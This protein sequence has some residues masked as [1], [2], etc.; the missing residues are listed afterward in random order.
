MFICMTLMTAKTVFSLSP[1]EVLIVYNADKSDSYAVAEYYRAARNI[2]STNMLGVTGLVHDMGTLMGRML[3]TNYRDQVETPVKMKLSDLETIGVYIQCIVTVYGIPTTVWDGNNSNNPSNVG[4]STTWASLDSELAVIGRGGNYGPIPNPY[5]YFYWNGF[6]WVKRAV[7]P[8]HF[9]RSEYGNI[10]L[11]CRIQGDSKAESIELI[12]RALESETIG[13]RGSF[14]IDASYGWPTASTEFTN[15]KMADAYHLVRNE[16]D[17]PANLNTS[18]GYYKNPPYDLKEDTFFYW[19]WYD[20]SQN[21][22]T[23]P[24]VEGTDNDNGHDVYR[25]MP[26]SVGV[27][28]ISW[29]DWNST[30]GWLRGMLDDGITAT[31]YAVAEP[32]TAGFSDPY[33]FLKYYL[34]G[35]TYAEAI[36]IS[37]RFLSWQMVIIGDPLMTYR[38]HKTASIK[39]INHNQDNSITIIWD[40]PCESLVYRIDAT[41]DLINPTWTQVEPASQWPI[42][43]TTWTSASTDT[44]A[45]AYYKLVS[46]VPYISSVEPE[47]VTRG[48]A[49]FDFLVSVYGV[50]WEPTINVNFGDG[51]SVQTISEVD[52]DTVAV[53]VT[54]DESTSTG[55]RDVRLFNGSTFYRKQNAVDIQ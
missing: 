6:D 35:Y 46:L 50:S 42:T 25:F 23:D 17:L 53:T 39:T 38:R 10:M 43:G 55:Y 22:R 45:T 48:A 54:I 26:G 51:I 49:N 2:P 36:Y 47:S 31:Q 13:S 37:M 18:S 7:D 28:V 11:V 29:Q 34:E 9:T 27:H 4:F 1:Q 24:D 21:Y 19:G 15:A 40:S 5:S 20:P 16:Y 32:F 52:S 3:T 14:M 33:S 44:P 41:T 8:G 12:D 30:N